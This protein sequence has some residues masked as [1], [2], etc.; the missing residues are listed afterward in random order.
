M[1]ADSVLTHT[2]DHDHEEHGHPTIRQ[3]VYI[4]IFLTI[5]TI[6]EVAIYYVDWMHETGALVPS[7]FVLSLAKF[8]TV[9]AY[10]MHLKTDDL[11]FRYMFV[12]GLVVSIAVL[13]ALLILMDV[14]R[15]SYAGGLIS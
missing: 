4:A 5:V 2:I 8:V 3:Y 15:I 11:R 9:I 7:L 10:Y 14:N 1:M 6:V 13:G 12:A